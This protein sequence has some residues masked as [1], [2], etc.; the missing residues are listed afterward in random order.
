M[1]DSFQDEIPKAR[2][3]IALELDTGGARKKTELPLKLLAMGD[4]S[5]GKSDQPLAER[6][7][8]EVSR[9]NLE[10]V[11]E[12]LAPEAR[13]TVENRLKEEGDE[14]PVH[15]KFDSFDAFRPES[16]ARQVPQLATMLAMRNLLKDLKS[17]LMDNGRFRKELEKV[18][19]DSEETEQL[20]A[21]L[22]RLVPPPGQNDGDS[23]GD[24]ADKPQ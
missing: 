9:N 19:G 18:L 11:L 6:E 1:S 22:A 16:V 7:R 17:N 23:N 2:V 8:I 3:N 13:F 24:G 5:N 12:N 10:Q 14:I 20:A 4:F 15:M 21:D